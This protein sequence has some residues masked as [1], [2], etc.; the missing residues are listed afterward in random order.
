M[1]SEPQQFIDHNFNLTIFFDKKTVVNWE[2][3]K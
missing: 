3:Y 1:R 2:V